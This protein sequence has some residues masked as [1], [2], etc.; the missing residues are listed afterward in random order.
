[1]N[2]FRSHDEATKRAQ[3]YEQKKAH[4]KRKERLKDRNKKHR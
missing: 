4:K 3:A 1:M 2:N